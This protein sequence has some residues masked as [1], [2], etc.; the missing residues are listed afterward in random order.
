MWPGCGA[1][2][3]NPGLA[4]SLR[5]ALPCTRPAV[6]KGT[7]D[8]GS[9]V[10]FGRI[11]RPGSDRLPGVI[12]DLEAGVAGFA[13]ANALRRALLSAAAAATRVAARLLP[14]RA[15]AGSQAAA[16]GRRQ[17]RAPGSPMPSRSDRGLSPGVPS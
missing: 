8:A 13:C 14:V 10:R 17:V 3:I 1:W 15:H 12:E 11:L 4:G 6:S 9:T 5:A 16:P 2:L 7:A